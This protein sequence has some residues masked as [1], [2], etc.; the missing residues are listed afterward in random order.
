MESWDI[1][2]ITSYTEKSKFFADPF[3]RK[4]QK[5]GE[6]WE[7]W[8]DDYGCSSCASSNLNNP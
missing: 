7:N 3:T 4:C 6:N 2:T 1:V 8:I 5:W